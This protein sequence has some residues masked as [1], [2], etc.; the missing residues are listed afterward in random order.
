MKICPMKP[1]AL[2][3][4]LVLLLISVSAI[5]EEPVEVEFSGSGDWLSGNVRVDNTLPWEIQYDIDFESITQTTQADC[6]ADT[7]QVL[8][9]NVAVDHYL[10]SEIQAYCNGNQEYQIASSGQVW[11]GGEW[12]D[13]PFNWSDNFA[14]P[15]SQ[16]HVNINYDGETY[17]WLVV[18]RENGAVMDEFTFDAA[19]MTEELK[20]CTDCEIMVYRNPTGLLPENFTLAYTNAEPKPVDW[21]LKAKADRKSIDPEKGEALSLTIDMVSSLGVRDRLVERY[22][23]GVKLNG[24]ELPAEAFAVTINSNGS[25]KVEITPEYLAEHGK[26]GE[27]E[28]AIG[29]WEG[30]VLKAPFT[31]K[32]TGNMITEDVEFSGMDDW[33]TGNVRVDNT[34][35]WEIQ[36]DVDFE[37]ITKYALA[38]RWADTIQVIVQNV[39]LDHYLM[40]EVQAYCNANLKYQIASSGQ[41]WKGNEWSD[42]PFNWSENFETPV[43]QLHVTISYDGETY[44][45]LV[46]NREDGA[47]M[48]EFTF[49]AAQLTE[50]LKSC[51]DCV[52]K[53]YRNPTYLVLENF[54]IAYAE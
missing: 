13:R 4:A 40:S 9:R 48:D 14:D 36:Y 53:V 6:W 27:N 42:R 38:D 21:Y 19:Q 51:T 11:K 15:V 20:S 39:E 26:D 34:R 22:V 37:S 29:W 12:S 2:L 32:K 23:K 3:M 30:T 33:L 17:S 49:D 41:V 7:I 45:W 54:T 50:E 8:V 18:N 5:A 31:V 25:L 43:T 24:E 10:K 44:S 52:I 47:V 28:V 16:L 1:L 46:I 35:P